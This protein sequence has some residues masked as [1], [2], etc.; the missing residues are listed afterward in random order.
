MFDTV[1]KVEGAEYLILGTWRDSRTSETR[2]YTQHLLKWLIHRCSMDGAVCMTCFWRS[3]DTID[4]LGACLKRG[5]LQKDSSRGPYDPLYSKSAETAA[6]RKT[7]WLTCRDQPAKL[8]TL[9]LI[10][11]HTPFVYLPIPTVVV[12]GACHSLTVNLC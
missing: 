11:S 12:Y 10:W 6:R 3:T 2:E 5:L 9:K 8:Q 7:I 4:S 1:D